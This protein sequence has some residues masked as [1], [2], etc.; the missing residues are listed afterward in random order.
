MCG[1]KSKRGLKNIA[2]LSL[3]LLVALQPLAA[4]KLPAWLTGGETEVQPVSKTLLGESKQEDLETIQSQALY[5]TELEQQLNSLIPILEGYKKLEQDYKTLYQ[6]KGLWSKDLRTSIEN[7]LEL[8][9]SLSALTMTA[10]EISKSDKQDYDIVVK[11]YAE[12]ADESNEYFKELADAEAKL[13]AIEKTKW[14][15]MV[16]ATALFKPSALEYGVGLEL[17]VGYGSWMLKVGADYY[18]PTDIALS[19]FSFKDLD[20][21][22]GLQFTF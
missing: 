2:I 22:A 6:E 17:G 1:K 20:Y 5:I 12:K 3:L 15:G 11:A 8:L 10:E 7:S 4:W 16:G 13:A 14:S 18:I 9:G 19:G 21:R